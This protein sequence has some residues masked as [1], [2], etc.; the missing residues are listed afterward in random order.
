M[1]ASWPLLVLVAPPLTPRSS[2]PAAPRQL[3]SSPRRRRAGEAYAGA[4]TGVDRIRDG[5]TDAKAP[6]RRLLRAVADEGCKE[7]SEGNVENP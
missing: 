2:C 6:A 5:S 4:F 7:S 1:F 3:A